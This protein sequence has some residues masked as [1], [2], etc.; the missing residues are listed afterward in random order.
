MLSYL[1]MCRSLTYAQRASKLLERS[2]ITAIITKIPQSVVGGGCQYCIKVN[3]SRLTLALSLLNRNGF[4]PF[5]VFLQS[6][7]GSVSE[8]AR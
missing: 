6:Q 5:R 7:D 4:S 3:E 2:G 8:V 1:L